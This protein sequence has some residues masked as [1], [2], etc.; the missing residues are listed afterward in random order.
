MKNKKLLIVE[1][2]EVTAMNLRFSLEKQ[3]Y[4]NITVAYDIVSAK[5]KI[6]L[7]SPDIILIDIS[8]NDTLDGIDL[9]DTIHKNNAI[10]FIFLTAHTD[11]DILDAASKT[12]PYGFIV[13]PF[14]PSAVHAMIKMALYKHAQEKK[15]ENDQKSLALLIPFAELYHFDMENC[16]TFYNNEKLNLTKSENLLMQ[17][18]IT[19]LGSIISF[20]FLIEHIWKNN[21][22][23]EY[24]VRT[25]V[26]RLRNKLPTDI[27]KSTFGIGYYIE[28]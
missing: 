7:L 17:L 14:K 9:A 1:D 23:T 19:K 22:G 6:A 21:K 2:D 5:N 28:K 15:R 25:L 26:W 16:Q 24:S 12:E 4:S 11:E 3:N 13:K 18:F 10:P 20:D 8:L 27:I